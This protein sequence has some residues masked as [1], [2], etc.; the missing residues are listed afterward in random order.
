MYN[1]LNCNHLHGSRVYNFNLEENKMIQEDKNMIIEELLK[2]K[3]RFQLKTS[4]L[5]HN[6][7]NYHELSGRI[8][9]Y[10][11]MIAFINSIKC[12]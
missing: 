6:S 10:N 4:T 12:K 8:W 2:Q 11:D 7:D 9:A 3:R 1:W 5:I